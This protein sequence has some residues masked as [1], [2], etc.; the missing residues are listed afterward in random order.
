MW[1]LLLACAGG[2]S[3]DLPP[4]DSDADCMVEVTPPD[5]PV[6]GGPPV[7]A[8][9]L[10]GMIVW[11]ADF[12]AE[13][14]ARG[15]VDCSY[16]RS[17][18]GT[19][20]IDQGYLCPDCSFLAPAVTEMI[21]GYDDCYGQIGTQPQ[22]H[23]EEVGL[24]EVD[25]ALHFFRTSL[26]NAT[27]K[28]LGAVEG[29]AA[30]FRFLYEEDSDLTDGGVL[31]LTLS[32]DFQSSS[33]TEMLEDPQSL[34]E[35]PYACG[36]PR[37]NPGG[38]N[39]SYTLAEGE[40]FPNVRLLDRCGER[41]SLWDFRGFYL[42]VDVSA[43]NCSYCQVMAKGA[44]GFKA[45]MEEACVPVE[46]ITLMAESLSTVNIPASQEMLEAWTDTYGL[47]SPVLA[48]EGFGYA[49]L[50]E[51]VGEDNFGYPTTAIL[52][53]EGR[54]IGTIDGFSTYKDENGKVTGDAWD[55]IEAIILKD[56]SG[57]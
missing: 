3:E 22:I 15:L 39:S 12:D 19:E 30:A 11:T 38:P 16:T 45:R 10:A 48:D 37:N 26:E 41:V 6:A 20:R 2:K 31:S 35:E 46:M 27:L 18:S 36:W 53:P 55:D 21:A 4:E 1:W 28:D 7:A 9:E 43:I 54:L 24:G 44:E 50:R 47:S 57:R 42:V 56:R 8:R 5:E 40:V 17:Y 33:G 29:D 23:T 25:G 52:D 51:Y 34:R 14:E 32:G 13:A 49:R